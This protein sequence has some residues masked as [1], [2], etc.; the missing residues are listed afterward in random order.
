MDRGC[1]AIGAQVTGTASSA[2]LRGAL[3][4]PNTELSL[5]GASSMSVGSVVADTITLNQ[6]ATLKT[7]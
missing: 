1:G 7:E 6:G 3:Y 5:N 2:T 4:A